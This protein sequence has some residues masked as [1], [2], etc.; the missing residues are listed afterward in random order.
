MVMW[1]FSLVALNLGGD[2]N[3]KRIHLIS[4]TEVEE[5]YG[6]F[7]ISG[8]EKPQKRLILLFYM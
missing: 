7:D 8:R 1:P 3:T 4:S 5:L 6:Y 2:G